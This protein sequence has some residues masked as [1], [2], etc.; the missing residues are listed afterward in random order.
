MSGMSKMQ[1]AYSSPAITATGL[2]E[3]VA[4]TD[5]DKRGRL[6]SKVYSSVTSAI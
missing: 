4:P 2:S 6:Q 1:V 5:G 3:Y